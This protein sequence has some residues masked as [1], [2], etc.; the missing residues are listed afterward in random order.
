VPLPLVPTLHPEPPG[1]AG[2]TWAYLLVALAAGLVA[3]GGGS[4]AVTVAE[5]RRRTA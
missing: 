1:L 2:G 4:L 3:L 5:L